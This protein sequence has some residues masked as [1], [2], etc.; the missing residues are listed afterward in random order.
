MII[1]K[2]IFQ[3][4]EKKYD[5]FFKFKKHFNGQYYNNN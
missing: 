4:K 1:L 3:I 2:R 5:T